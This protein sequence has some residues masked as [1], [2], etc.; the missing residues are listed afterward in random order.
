MN[1][2]PLLRAPAAPKPSIETKLCYRCGGRFSVNVQGGGFAQHDP[3]CLQRAIESDARKRAM[4]EA[5]AQ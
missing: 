4:R 1:D 3:V 2:T 5:S